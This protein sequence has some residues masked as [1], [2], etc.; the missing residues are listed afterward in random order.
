MS[1]LTKIARRFSALHA[2]RQCE[3]AG[4]PLP[5]PGLVPGP[6]G[7]VT[8]DLEKAM[9]SASDGVLGVRIT[10]LR[11][12]V[13][14]PD[15]G[16]PEVNTANAYYLAGDEDALFLVSVSKRKSPVVI[17]KHTPFVLGYD[18]IERIHVLRGA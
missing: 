5:G 9:E 17:Q 14:N 12:Y 8:Q 3:A 10:L 7:N 13:F 6:G 15:A 11:R 18:K 4:L 16:M 2:A 1:L